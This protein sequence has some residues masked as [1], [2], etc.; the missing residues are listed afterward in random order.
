MNPDQNSDPTNTRITSHCLELGSE[1]ASRA[2]G[3]KFVK[4][5]NGSAVYEVASGSYTVKS[6]I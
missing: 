6:G 2:E 4:M 5:E 3:V 1:P